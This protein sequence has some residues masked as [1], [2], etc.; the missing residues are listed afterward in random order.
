MKHAPGIA[1]EN[2]TGHPQGQAEAG[3]SVGLEQWLEGS[4]AEG[5]M[6]GLSL[7]VGALAGSCTSVWQMATESAQVQAGLVSYPLEN[8]FYLYHLKLWTLSVQ[9]G[10]LG[11]AAGL[12]EAQVNIGLSALL[13]ALLFAGLSGITFA[14]SRRL[15][16]A[17]VLPV[18]V[19]LSE[20]YHVGTTYFIAFLGN[21]HTFGIIG[22]GMGLVMLA[23][24][25]LGRWRLLAFLTGLAPAVHP[26]TGLWA[27]GMVGLG[28]LWWLLRERQRQSFQTLWQA[29]WW[30]P[31]LGSFVLGVLLSGLSF[32]HHLWLARALPPIDP[33]LAETYLSS[34]IRYW[35][36][37]RSPVPLRSWGVPYG[38]LTLLGV[39]GW[40]RWR[41]ATLSESSRRLLEVVGISAGLSLGFS[42]LSHVQEWLP[43]LVR[44]A[45][46]WRNL[47][48]T[49]L[50]FPALLVGFLAQVERVKGRQGLLLGLSLG[51]Q[52]PIF[53]YLTGVKV[54]P[55][56]SAGLGGL[57]AGW[58]QRP[59]QPEELG[60]GAE[61]ASPAEVGSSWEA[62][63]RGARLGL[64]L[65]LVG[66]GLMGGVWWLGPGG[67]SPLRMLFPLGVMVALV[68]GGW[69]LPGRA[70]V[71]R[72]LLLLLGG[73]L[74]LALLA[75]GVA[76]ME[77]LKLREV[78]LADWRTDPLLS[79]ASR[80]PGLLVTAGDMTQIQ[81]RT[82]RP[83]L[84]HGY[85]LNTLPYVLESGPSM[86]RGLA[87]VYGISLR[88][89]GMLRMGG[90][91]RE[92]G[93]TLW[94]RRSPEEWRRL[95]AS[96]ELGGVMTPADWQLQLPL[97]M[98]DRFRALYRVE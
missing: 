80:V 72:G 7:L 5:L 45:M 61:R 12:T 87:E 19:E 85:N 63:R 77:A 29:R 31:V 55:L 86:E 54:L 84:L 73:V 4:R 65:F 62:S 28:L 15:G 9:L 48:V 43:G 76:L 21:P 98:R 10:A 74:G 41:E 71:Q 18:L 97:I 11:L 39:W 50:A 32:A 60:Q 57:L 46:P 20:I 70:E 22:N 95:A 6:W 82:R 42:V 79:E 40:L 8:S 83:V 13:G 34:F 56:V 47:N 49:S 17:L 1:P 53:G 92:D 2:S 68:G 35:D 25:G 81:L 64:L 78:R 96:F 27:S 59:V 67:G 90:L 51:L 69:L 88:S 66:V 30:R 14:L 37:H 33:A 94:E 26:S 36:D 89:P 58:T 75:E 16:L 44:A 24:L 23:A 3:R 91:G 38:V 52:V 93:R